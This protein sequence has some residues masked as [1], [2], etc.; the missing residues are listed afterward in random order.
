MHWQVSDPFCESEYMVL[1]LAGVREQ[2]VK[3][4]KSTQGLTSAVLVRECG[5]V[6]TVGDR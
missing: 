5:A 6:Q 4:E 1:S 3:I 2:L